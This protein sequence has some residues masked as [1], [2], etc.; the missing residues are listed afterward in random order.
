MRIATLIGTAGL[1]L[2]TAARAQ[3]VT[4]DYDKTADFAALKSYAWARGTP[5]GDEL[6]H[7]RIVAAVEAQLA[8]KGLHP[9]EPGG[10]PDVLVAYHA[11]FGRDVEVTGMSS[12]W[13]AY[14]WAPSRSGSARAQEILVGA[15]VVDMV[16]ARS[17][18]IVWRGVASKDV[19]VKASPEKREKNINKAAE[20]LFQ[21]YPPAR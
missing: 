5:V 11:I 4:Y 16:D 19:D 3:E 20:K 7:K 1:L 10:T 21:H 15:L 17:R 8:A 14:R 9:V 12:G 2:S 6:N 18:T 13:G